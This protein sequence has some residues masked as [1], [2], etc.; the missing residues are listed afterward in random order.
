MFFTDWRLSVRQL[1]NRQSATREEKE[2][3]ASWDSSAAL[4]STALS[5]F[6][7]G[8]QHAHFLS[9]VVEST[10]DSSYSR[11]WGVFCAFSSSATNQSSVCCICV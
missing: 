8:W 9:I 5:L 2:S 1:A 3:G 11:A 10:R 7:N 6:L 4:S